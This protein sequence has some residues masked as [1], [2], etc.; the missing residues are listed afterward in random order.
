MLTL[1][2]LM[3]TNTNKCWECSKKVGIV[4]VPCK[5]SFV[6]CPKHR[7]AEDHNCSFD[8]LAENQQRLIKNNPMIK[9]DKMEDRM[10]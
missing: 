10:F 5:C 9:A 4:R 6:Y 1:I 8:F 3:Q 7:H 2:F